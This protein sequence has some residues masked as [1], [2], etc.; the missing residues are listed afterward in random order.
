MVLLDFVIVIIDIFN[1]KEQ[2]FKFSKE[3]T[4]VE[5]TGESFWEYSPLTSS[6]QV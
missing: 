3:Q 2:M 1:Q 6:L 5:E 4:Y